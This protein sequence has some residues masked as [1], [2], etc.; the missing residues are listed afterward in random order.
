MVKKIIAISGIR[1]DYDI[2][3][4]VFKELDSDSEIDFK[5]IACGTHLLKKYGST[6]ELIEKDGFNI[7][8]KID[9]I[10]DSNTDGSRAKGI[11]ILI[12][13]LV[14]TVERL[15]P[16]YLLVLGDREESIATAIV[17][18]YIKIPVIHIGGGDEPY[19]NADDPIR[20]A[21]SKLSHIHFT[22]CEKF[23]RNLLEMGEEEF[24]VFNV[25][26]PSLDRIRNTTFLTRDELSQSLD[27]NLGDE[28]EPFV[29]VL[30]HPLSSEVESSYM[31][32]RATIDAIDKLEI[33]AV[34]IYPNSDPGS[35]GIIKA[36]E[37]CRVNKNIKIFENLDR[38]QFINALR[39]ATC[40]IGNSSSGLLEAPF[41][42]KPAIN[43]GNRQKGRLNAGNVIFIPH[44]IDIIK[45]T[46][47]KLIFDKK[48]VDSIINGTD[49]N[50]Y[51]DSY[52]TQ[53]ILKIIK[54]ID[55]DDNLMVKKNSWN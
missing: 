43:V 29:V 47:H 27:F 14:Q 51:G 10:L 12:Q 44:E 37:E 16:D 24:R 42:K 19:G 2:M 28:S 15:K 7:A 52:S 53:K 48:F 4:P 38:L 22:F 5:I 35:H 34:I 23:R 17:G 18:N 3:Y 21:T 36:I 55:I 39:H 11:G 1:S 31:Q 30:Q 25:G 20:H 49:Q 41:L 45:Q 50:Y 54:E 46:I 32:M 6:I 13:S 40:L 8:E 33:K 26:N 9:Y